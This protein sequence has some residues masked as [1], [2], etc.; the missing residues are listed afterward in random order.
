VLVPITL[1]APGRITEWVG[2]VPTDR[3]DDAVA[4]LS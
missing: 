4:A 3:P 2:D 1:N